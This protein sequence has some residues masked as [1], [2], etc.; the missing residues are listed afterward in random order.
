[1][2][3]MTR[4]K[5]VAFAKAWLADLNARNIDGLMARYADDSVFVSSRAASFAH[6][7]SIHDKGTLRR[8]FESALGGAGASAIRFELD[9]LAWDPAEQ[10]LAVVH[11]VGVG[12]KKVRECEVMQLDGAGRVK[13][14]EA[15]YGGAA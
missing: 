5:A 11:V 4:E 7:T 15:F 8:Y 1:M 2:D 9:H 14:H 13:R 6:S 12:D 3:G 10:V